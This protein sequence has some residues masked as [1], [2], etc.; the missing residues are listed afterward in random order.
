MSK[1]AKRKNII[2]AV[3]AV[4]AV[5]AGLILLL[6]KGLQKIQE[7]AHN[8]PSKPVVKGVDPLLAIRVAFSIW[9]LP[10]EMRVQRG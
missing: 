3:I 8:I 4:I 1:T 2:L 7:P 10:E 5:A 6:E 9:E